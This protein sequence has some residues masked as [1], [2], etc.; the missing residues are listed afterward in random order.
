MFRASSA[1]PQEVN[2]VN[3]TCMQLLVF[4]FS[5]GGRLVHLLRGDW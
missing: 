5:A 3:Y 2:V 1:H 4:S